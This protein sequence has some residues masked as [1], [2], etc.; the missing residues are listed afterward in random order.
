MQ[1]ISGSLKEIVLRAISP[2]SVRADGQLTMPRSYGVYAL[3][4]TAGTTR[5]FR[6][7]NHPIRMRE[8]E[9]EFSYCTLK[10]LFLSRADAV[11]VASALNAGE[12]EL[13]SPREQSGAVVSSPE[14]EHFPTRKKYLAHPSPELNALFAHKPY[15]GATP[16]RARFLFIGLDAN[17]EAEIET[18]PI[19]SKIREYHNDGVAFWRKHGVHHPFLLPEYSGDGRHYHQSFS[20]I[21][22]GP[23]HADLVSFV[24][25][26]HVPTVGRN[27]LVANDLDAAH[28]NMLNA[29]IL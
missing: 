16:E 27:I 10:Y 17:Y 6:V 3:P 23:E 15:Q 14:F 2:L 28:L 11:E 19:F 5:R 26:F 20:R 18:K 12:T 13:F 21:G 1:P 29:A 22:F 7:G 4:A 25:L 8:L 9:H 24:E